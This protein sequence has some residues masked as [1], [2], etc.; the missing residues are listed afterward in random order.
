[1]GWCGYGRDDSPAFDPVAPADGEFHGGESAG[2]LGGGGAPAGGDAGTAELGRV[3]AGVGADVAGDSPG[4][5]G[6]GGND[7][8]PP[9]SGEN[10]G[11]PSGSQPHPG[12]DFFGY[13]FDYLYAEND[14]V[15]L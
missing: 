8:E 5:L 4:L 6:S 13:V 9:Y 7:G 12:V 1:M 11:T 14:C 3:G 2:G 15:E 10:S